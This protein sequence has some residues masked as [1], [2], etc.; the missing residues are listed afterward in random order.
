VHVAVAA[1]AAAAAC[2]RRYACDARNAMG[3]G[4]KGRERK[5]TK[6][7]ANKHGDDVTTKRAERNGKKKNENTREN[8]GN[9]GA[10]L[11]HRPSN[12]T[13]FGGVRISERDV[14]S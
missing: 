9:H 4:V 13:V 10:L 12:K 14:L 6:T 3:I 5:K 1:A 7:N 11:L 8:R 2:R